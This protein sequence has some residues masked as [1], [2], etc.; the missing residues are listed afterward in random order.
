VRLVGLFT[1][2]RLL[3]KTYTSLID[4][5]LCLWYCAELVHIKRQRYHIVNIERC[6]RDGVCIWSWSVRGLSNVPSRAG[7][8]AV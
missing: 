6:H 3:Q 7:T 2:A 5:D 4:S 1:C 8:T